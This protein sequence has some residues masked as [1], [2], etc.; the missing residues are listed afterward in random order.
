MKIK[1]AGVSDELQDKKYVLKSLIKFL[2]IFIIS[3]HIIDDHYYVILMNLLMLNL[4]INFEYST[5][6]TTLHEILNDI[7]KGRK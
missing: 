4:W 1:V 5:F 3:W 7:I 6:F 2:L